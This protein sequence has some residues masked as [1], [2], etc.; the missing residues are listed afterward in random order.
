MAEVWEESDM[1]D[2]DDQ[3]YTSLQMFLAATGG[4]FKQK[5]YFRNMFYIYSGIFWKYLNIYVKLSP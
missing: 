3:E 5:D 1:S 2:E 4:H